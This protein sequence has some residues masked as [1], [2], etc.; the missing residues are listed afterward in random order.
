MTL[1]LEILRD[2]DDAPQFLKLSG[3]K[4]TIGRAVRNDVI[5][6][7]PY[8]SAAHA[9]LSMN[10]GGWQITDLGSDNGTF[11]DGN[12]LSSS[13]YFAPGMTAT[14]GQTRLRRLDPLAD[15]GPAL[16]LDQT[17]RFLTDVVGRPLVVWLL[18][19]AVLA[20]NLGA[21]YA[22]RYTQDVGKSLSAVAAISSGLILG[23]AVPWA[24]AGRFL[25]GRAQ[26]TAHVGLA[27]L[28]LILATLQSTLQGF[29]DFVLC[30]NMF[31]DG[32]DVTVNFVLM[33]LLIFSGLLIASK[34]P[35]RKALMT[36]ALFSAGVL[37]VVIAM[38]SFSARDF[39]PT[40]DYPG[41]MQ[42]WP[43]GLLPA[44]N[45]GAFLDKAALQLNKVD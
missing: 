31:A 35:R 3:T 36:S 10:D 15:P 7:D 28:F 5:L 32:V 19:I 25:R 16:T 21:F 18:F 9:A 40:P 1:I 11:V 4:I 23:W 26:F 17:P 6:P 30:E 43:A 29:V 20:V 34:T 13:G 12:R 8:V 38:I 39:E 2:D 44:D 22:L 14:L 42:P 27:C 33:T 41:M 37:A 45:I 24:V